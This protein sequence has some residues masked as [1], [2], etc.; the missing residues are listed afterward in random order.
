MNLRTWTINKASKLKYDFGWDNL[1]QETW[2]NNGMKWIST[3]AAAN[4]NNAEIIR[5]PTEV[6]FF[7]I[8]KKHDL[9]LYCISWYVEFN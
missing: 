1:F 7:D 9:F 6:V 8:R 3:T 2:E 4:A 5:L